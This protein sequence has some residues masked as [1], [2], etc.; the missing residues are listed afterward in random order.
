[1][2]KTQED[3]KFYSTRDMNLAAVLLTL[4]FY[5]SGIDYQYEGGKVVG[6]F[7]F[8]KGTNIE[9]AIKKYEAG[10]LAMEPKTLLANVRLLKA[11]VNNM[12]NN[13]KQELAK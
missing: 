11:K 2:T 9:T 6:Y 10:D 12:Q 5:L 1:M 7:I 8:E 4:R 13:P 3:E